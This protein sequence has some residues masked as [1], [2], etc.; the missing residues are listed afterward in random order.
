MLRTSVHIV[1]GC[2]ELVAC[3]CADD[4]VYVPRLALGEVGSLSGFTRRSSSR[5]IDGI[6]RRRHAGNCV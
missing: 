5:R 3:D 1:N 6:V 4:D 2:L